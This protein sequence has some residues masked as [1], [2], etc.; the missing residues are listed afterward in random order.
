MG[1]LPYSLWPQ[2]MP[3]CHHNEA[4]LDQVFEIALHGVSAHVQRLCRISVA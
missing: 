2:E 1:A 4:A 3:L